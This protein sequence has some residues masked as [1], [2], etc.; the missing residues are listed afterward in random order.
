MNK[1]L[2]ALGLDDETMKHKHFKCLAS[3]ETKCTATFPN[4][5]THANVTLLFTHLHH[6]HP[7]IY[8]YISEDFRR[9][10]NIQKVDS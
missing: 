10:Y 8:E 3:D 2:F 6:E 5:R 1:H 4:K 7:V 9:W